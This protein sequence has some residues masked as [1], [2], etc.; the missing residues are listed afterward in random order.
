MNVILDIIK[1]TIFNMSHTKYPLVYEN[2]DD[3]WKRAFCAEHVFSPAG[4]PFIG[5]H[6]RRSVEELLKKGSLQTDLSKFFYVTLCDTLEFDDLTFEQETTL[7]LIDIVS[8]APQIKKVNEHER[9]MYSALNRLYVFK[10]CIS[11]PKE[12]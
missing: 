6:V 11:R 7:K 10:E 3:L 2:L 4:H 8:E 5:E 1:K 9:E 12:E